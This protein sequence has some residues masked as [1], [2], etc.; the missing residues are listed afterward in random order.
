[1]VLKQMTG[2]RHWQTHPR[3]CRRRS[4]TRRPSPLGRDRAER[5]VSLRPYGV[6][7]PAL[8]LRTPLSDL[9]APVLTLTFSSSSPSTRPLT[10]QPTPATPGPSSLLTSAPS[11]Q[12]STGPT[13]SSAHSR[14]SIS[15]LPRGVINQRY[16]YSF[17]IPENPIRS[18]ESPVK[19][20]QTPQTPT[21]SQ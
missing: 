18:H 19:P 11:I 7:Q 6:W 12:N 4:L 2:P 8:H 16:V 1:M 9:T 21:K 20:R 17:Q 14:A 15:S 3:R 13:S 10:C 5:Q